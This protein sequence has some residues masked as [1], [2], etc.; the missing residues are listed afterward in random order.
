MKQ[1]R[2]QWAIIA[3]FFL[4]STSLTAQNAWTPLQKEWFLRIVHLL[5]AAKKTPVQTVSTGAVC[6]TISNEIT[7]TIAP[8][9][10][11]LKKNASLPNKPVE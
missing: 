8:C 10:D 2:N 7:I 3:L 4:F 9:G 11:N 6:A 1:T 5:I